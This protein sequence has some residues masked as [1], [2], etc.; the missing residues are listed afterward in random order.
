MNAYESFSHSLVRSKLWLC[1]Q[2]EQ[3]LDN[4]SIKN[5]AVN[6]L[7]SWDSLLA[8]MM[9]T[10]RP[11]FYGVV[12]AYD[13]DSDAI[14]NA[15]KLCDHWIFEYPK[16]YNHT[17]DINTL[18]FSS[19]GN[20]SIFINCSVD[21]LDGT[22]WYDIIPDNRLVCLQTTNLPLSTTEWNIKQS[23]VDKSLFS[24]TYA[25]RRL[26]YCDSIDINYGHLNFKRHMMI[27]IK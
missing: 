9:L 16:V 2:L 22:E 18:D 3:V 13:V 23:Y 11:K 21:Q 7:A 4:E 14:E 8:F 1:E 12:N 17:K 25:V 15:N 20:E 10:R 26:I 19:T 5:P 27:G 24:K 6:I